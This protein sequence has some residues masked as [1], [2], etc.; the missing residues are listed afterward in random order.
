MHYWVSKEVNCH[1]NGLNSYTMYCG[2]I[3]I[4]APIATK[5][6]QNAQLRLAEYENQLL[7]MY[8][9]IYMKLIICLHSYSV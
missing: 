5:L 7:C 2:L 8:T 4:Y 9:R 3:Y 6:S 1:Q